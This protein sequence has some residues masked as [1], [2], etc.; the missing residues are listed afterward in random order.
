MVDRAEQYIS[1]VHRGRIVVGKWIKLAIERHQTDLKKA[2]K[3][4]YPYCFSPEHAEHVINV[5]SILKLAK[6]KERGKPFDI[7]PWQAAILWMAYGWRRKD[8]GLRRFRKIYIKVARGNAKTEFLS[9]VGTYGFLFEGEQDAEVYWVAT[10]K[11]Q[12]KIGWGRQKVM[13]EQLLLDEPELKNVVTVAAHKIFTKVGLGWVYYLGQDSN[14]EDG[15]SPY[16][17]LVDEFHA[18]AD[19]SMLNVIESGMGKR[20]DP[21]TWIIT[22]AGYLPNGPNASF[23]RACK[24]VLEG[25]IESNELLAFIYEIDADDDWKDED[26]WGKANPSLGVS[27]KLH[28]LRSEREKV[29]T[30]GMSKE[31]DFQVKNLNVEYNSQNGWIPGEIWDQN[32]AEINHED[33]KGRLCFGG[34]DLASVSDTNSSCL[35]FPQ[36]HEGERHIFLWRFWLPADTIDKR[37]EQVNYPQWVRDGWLTKTTA[38][39]N[40]ADYGQIKLDLVQDQ[41]NY[42][43]NSVNYDRW[44][45]M[46]I[47]PD[48]IDE[49]LNMVEFGQGYGSMSTPSKTF[50]RMM[51]SGECNHGNNPVARWM[52]SN[53][54][55]DR[56]PAGD[57]KPNKKASADKIDGIVAA[58]MAVGGWLTYLSEPKS[59]SYMDNNDLL[60]L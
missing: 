18:H 22:T 49:G 11:D 56:N 45:K 17:A 40:V 2:K 60:T 7:M 5:I 36:R 50:E 6:G 38:W 3:K 48:L 35:F 44:N 55:I 57:I 24:N 16:Y 12:A 1:D 15:G 4:D 28:S 21:M 47:V 33:L 54:F 59:G 30:Q 23:L 52:N 31:I 20:D 43:L 34:L 58:I 25:I 14:T 37:S 27:V 9:A 8:T 53:V 51:L 39:D 29:A 46:A 42:D 19:D 13:T 10:K 32:V 26:C 41:G